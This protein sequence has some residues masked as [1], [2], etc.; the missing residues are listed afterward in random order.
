MM[1]IGSL[2]ASNKI[3]NMVKENLHMYN[4]AP[5]TFLLDN[6]GLT[7]GIHYQTTN[8]INDLAKWVEK[9]GAELTVVGMEGSQ[10]LVEITDPVALQ[11]ESFLN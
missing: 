8:K 4:E 11:L 5:M 9:F 1:T 7:W 6:K 2:Q 3:G 10:V